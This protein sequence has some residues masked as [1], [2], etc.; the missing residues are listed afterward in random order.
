MF[1]N[2]NYLVSAPTA[3]CSGTRVQGNGATI[4]AATASA[5]PG[6]NMGNAFAA[7]NVSGVT[8]E[9]LNFAYPHGYANYGPNAAAHILG[10]FGCTNVRVRNCN[11]DGG[12]NLTACI[13][14]T[15][16]LTTGCRATNFDNCAYDHWGGTTDARVIGNYAATL[17]TPAHGGVSCVNFT[18][19]NTDQTAASG[20]GFICSGNQ[21]Y[22]NM[23]QAQGICINGYNGTGGAD[24]Q[25]IITG[26]KITAT[27]AGT[28]GVLITGNVNNAIIEGNIL[29]GAA[30]AAYGAIGAYTAATNVRISHNVAVGWNAGS[31]GVFSN[32]TVG[33]SLEFNAAYGCSS[34]LIG[35]TDA[36]TMQIGN[37]TGSG[38]I[39]MLS[40]QKSTP[41]A[42]DAAAAAGGVQIGQLYRTA[43]SA[44]MIRVT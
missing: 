40:L 36:T 17:A 24:D 20:A 10:F 43:A 27:A 31:N 29:V 39:S 28:W 25:V 38:M 13:G 26:N 16:V 5:W 2:G 18:G 1:S 37:D 11:S 9:G 32:T 30:A 7:T 12:S 33:G 23:A 14:C 44:V 19:I 3:L 4:T 34:P 22:V 35:G 21:L 42:N 41:Y 8:I 6:G 15:D